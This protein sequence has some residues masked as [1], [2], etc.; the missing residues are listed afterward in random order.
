MCTRVCRYRGLYNNLASEMYVLFVVLP[1]S[2]LYCW[3]RRRR[4]GVL[5]LSSRAVSFLRLW[6]FA[7]GTPMFGRWIVCVLPSRPPRPG[8]GLCSLNSAVVSS[9]SGRMSISQRLNISAQH[10]LVVASHGI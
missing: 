4:R 9:S 2:F 7:R 8:D 1:F 6:F 3:G 5:F 10:H